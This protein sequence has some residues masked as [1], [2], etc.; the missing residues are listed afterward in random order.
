MK[1]KKIKVYSCNSYLFFNEG[2]FL[3]DNNRRDLYNHI[4]DT[5]KSFNI[6]VQDIPE[7]K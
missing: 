3:G 2:D 7:I 6:G 4:N 1:I 5:F